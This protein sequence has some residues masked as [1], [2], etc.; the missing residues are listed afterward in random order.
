[1]LDKVSKY[2]LYENNTWNVKNRH[3]TTRRPTTRK[4]TTRQPTTRKTTTRR[5]T[6]RKTATKKATTKQTT[7][8][9]SCRDF[10][11]ACHLWA[12]SG[13]G[14]ACELAAKRENGKFMLTYCC[15]SCSEKATTTQ[16]KPGLFLFVHMFL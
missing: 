16:P 9:S 8:Q 11:T 2:E 1:M 5:T 7:T 12:T 6:T 4:T 13:R 10:S 14:D 15:K 3:T